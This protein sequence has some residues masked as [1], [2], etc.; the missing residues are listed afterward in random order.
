MAPARSEVDAGALDDVDGP[1][2]PGAEMDEG[3]EVGLSVPSIVEV[4]SEP[5]WPPKTVDVAYP[6]DV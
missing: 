5:Y 1:E 3:L 6:D 4:E 2:P